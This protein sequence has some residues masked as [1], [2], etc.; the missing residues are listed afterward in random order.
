MSRCSLDIIQ[1]WR[2]SVLKLW[3]YE[4]QINNVSAVSAL[5]EFIFRIR[6][7]Q[8]KLQPPFGLYNILIYKSITLWNNFYISSFCKYIIYIHNCIVYSGNKKPASFR[9]PVLFFVCLHPDL[10]RFLVRN[11]SELPSAAT[12]LSDIILLDFFGAS[13]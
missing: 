8:L 2:W 1:I 6:T 7:V 13:G 10:Q 3:N 11:L 12:A 4:K 9:L 5:H